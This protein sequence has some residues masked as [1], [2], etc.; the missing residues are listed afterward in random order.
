[1]MG[2]FFYSK[3]SETSEISEAEQKTTPDVKKKTRKPKEIEKLRSSEWGAVIFK[4]F[5]HNFDTY[6]KRVVT[7]IH[8][9]QEVE[10]VNKDP[11]F[12]FYFKFERMKDYELFSD[13]AKIFEAKTEISSSSE[14]NTITC[15]L[16]EKPKLKT[17]SYLFANLI[18]NKE[19]LEDIMPKMTGRE[20]N[21]GADYMR[22]ITF[23]ENIR[24]QLLDE[25]KS[26]QHVISCENKDFKVI[27]EKAENTYMHIYTII[28][29]LD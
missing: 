19:W 8:H 13:V 3:N 25:L 2:N 10:K 28:C 4:S 26:C 23:N 16:C 18:Y 12:K 21:N 20:R 11:L 27:Y 6:Y 7:A 1:M 15:Y 24:K 9:L 14:D 5:M 17:K 29:N 22:F